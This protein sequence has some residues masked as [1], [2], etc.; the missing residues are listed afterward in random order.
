M[1]TIKTVARQ[2][3]KPQGSGNAASKA[4]QAFYNAFVAQVVADNARKSF[5]LHP[6]KGE[7]ARGVK[8]SLSRAITRAKRTDIDVSFMNADGTLTGPDGEN[9]KLEHITHENGGYLL[10]NLREALDVSG[11]E[12]EE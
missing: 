9:L 5:P 11:E 4:S 1:A 6:D 12:N 2:E 10:V 3:V 7:T 8:T